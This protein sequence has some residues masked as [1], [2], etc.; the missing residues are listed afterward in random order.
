MTS[1]RAEILIDSIN[2]DLKSTL[3]GGQ[4]FRWYPD[5]TGYRGVIDNQ[6]VRFSRY[7]HGLRVEFIN[8]IMS[9]G[10]EEKIYKYLGIDGTFE[11][12]YRSYA[13]DKRLGLAITN[14]SGMRILRQDPWECLVSFITSATSNIPRIKLN[15]NSIVCSLG[16]RIGPG[17]HDY[18]FPNPDTI[19]LAGEEMLRGHGLG[20]RAPY[21]VKAARDVVSGKINFKRLQQLPFDDARSELQLLEGVGEKI[22]DCVL[23]FS[24][25]KQEAFPIDR[26]VRRALEEWCGMPSSLNNSK[27]ADWARARF[28][29]NGAYVQQYLFHR[30]RLAARGHTTQ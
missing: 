16:Q 13:G 6:V 22:A 2:I 20:F 12:F 14:W 21:I 17:K 24:L 3:D 7:K 30:Q 8:D 26:W 1:D 18:S 19:A 15:V 9:R 10:I 4:A 11:S 27:A 23:A 25:G 5:A 29:H 28:G